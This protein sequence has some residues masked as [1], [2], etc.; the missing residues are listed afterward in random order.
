MDYRKEKLLFILIYTEYPYEPLLHLLYVTQYH[1]SLV[2][3]LPRTFSTVFIFLL[4]FTQKNKYPSYHM[5]PSVYT[6]VKL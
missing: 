5:N 2:Q 3:S 4:F 1:F 6:I